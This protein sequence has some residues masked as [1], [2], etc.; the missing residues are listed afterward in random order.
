M[1]EQTTIVRKLGVFVFLTLA[2]SSVSYFAMI[3]SGT[4]HDV[5]LLWM[6]SPGLAAI[7][8]QLIFRGSLKEFGWR[9]GPTRYL[10]SAALIP[11]AYS[12]TIYGIA[13]ITGL[14]GFKSPS[15]NLLIAFV[16]GLFFACFAALGEEIGWRGLLVPHLI[17][18]TSFTKTVLISWILW[19]LWHYPAIIWADYHSDAPRWFDLTSLTIAIVGLSAMTAWMRLKSGSIW[20][21][22]IWHGVH[23]LLIQGI[24]LSM[25][26]ETDVSAYVVDDFG[27]GVMITGVVL[28]IVFLRKG[29]S[30]REDGGIALVKVG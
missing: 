15:S 17:K 8:T 20:P 4:A 23:N 11:L 21:P 25:T 3:S 2:I 9:L 13:W 30:L 27:I 14:A 1:S 22:V 10:L 24:L 7:L 18:I 12:V 5:V 28:A 29:T 26:I 19:A 6:W 16:P